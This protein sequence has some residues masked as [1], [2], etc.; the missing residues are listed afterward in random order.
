MNRDLEDG[1]GILMEEIAKTKS[2]R[3]DQASSGGAET[4]EPLVAHPSLL[5]DG[6]QCS[7]ENPVLPSFQRS[8][9]A[10]LFQDTKW[11][12]ESLDTVN[13]PS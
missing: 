12:S 9:E 2:Q 10:P 8:R 11:S 7:A 5:R 4:T 1:E 6:P 3:W 13:S